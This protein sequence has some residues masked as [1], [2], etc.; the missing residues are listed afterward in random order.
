MRSKMTDYDASAP[1]LTR[2]RRESDQTPISQ[3]WTDARAGFETW[4]RDMRARGRHKLASGTLHYFLMSLVA[5]DVALLLLK[6]FLQLIA[7]EM[8]QINEPW[9]MGTHESLETIGIIFSVFFLLELVA[10]VTS[11]GFS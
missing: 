2:L 6:V 3:S 7:C 10:S 1:L 5:L 9:V 11:F 4:V 8:H